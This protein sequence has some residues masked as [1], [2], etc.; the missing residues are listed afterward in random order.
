MSQ[1]RH[2]FKSLLGFVLIAYLFLVSFCLL[3]EEK[4]DSMILHEPKDETQ[5]GSNIRRAEQT[6]NQTISKLYLEISSYS[7]LLN[8]KIKSLPHRTLVKKGTAKGEDCIIS[9]TEKD[10]DCISIEQ[11]DFIEGSFGEAKG[12]KSKLIVLFFDQK[13]SADNK[14]LSP[15][16]K[17][18]KSRIYSHNYYSQDKTW[19]EVV[20][21]DPLGNPD[22]DDKIIIRSESNPYFSSTP[23]KTE[24][25]GNRESYSLKSIENTKSHPIRNH[26]KREAYSKHLQLFEKLLARILNFNLKTENNKN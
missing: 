20:D 12:T 26:F 25:V 10:V 11:F 6:L 21:N 22:H 15:K 2:S 13:A 1:D 18:V 4:I 19:M 17:K 8:L 14:D 23:V 3:A 5:Y 7:N 24:E 16:L 9:T